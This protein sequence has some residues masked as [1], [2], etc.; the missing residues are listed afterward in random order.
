M[1]RAARLGIVLAL[2]LSLVAALVIVGIAAH[3]L[4]VFAEGADYLADA[5][6]IGVVLFALRLSARPPSA[7]R[8]QGYPKAGAWAALINAGWLLVLTV[9]VS[10]GAIDR[11]ATGT[12]PVHGLAVLIISGTAAL[13][14]LLGA[15]ILGGEI[16]L[17]DNDDPDDLTMRAV[18][19]DTAAD[20]G[21][22]AGVAIA[23]ALIAVTGGTYWLDPTV[24][25]VV[26][27]VVAY[28]AIQLLRKVT[29]AL[30]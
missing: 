18:L 11:L 25:L 27:G 23:G 26:S 21:A 16:D 5:A 22:A 30:R 4:G 9:L 12:H 29:V 10:A 28:H 19:L 1:R 8:P 7:R 14:M 15:L 24:A 6:A 20:A 13:V 17:L 2:N 3:S